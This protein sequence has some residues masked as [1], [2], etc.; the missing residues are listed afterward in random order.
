MD[1]PLDQGLT[2]AATVTQ[3]DASQTG[4]FGPAF[5]RWRDVPF[6]FWSG[7]H[8]RGRMFSASPLKTVFFPRRHE[9]QPA[10]LVGTPFLY[11]ALHYKSTTPS[12]PAY[13]AGHTGI[14]SR[15][16][17]GLAV[18]KR[19]ILRGKMPGPGGLARPGPT[20]AFLPEGCPQATRS[21]LAQRYRFTTSAAAGEAGPDLAPCLHMGE[22]SSPYS[23]CTSLLLQQP[24]PPSFLGS[25]EKVTCWLKQKA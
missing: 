15:F 13:D 24:K 17:P 19:S 18:G 1:L 23:S 22:D 6:A 2:C 12:H 20:D 4:R 16:H 7:H 5:C 10:G 8:R 14:G 9:P 21:Q 3:D 25:P 11:D